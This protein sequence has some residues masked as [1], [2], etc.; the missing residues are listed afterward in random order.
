MVNL[1]WDM[2]VHPATLLDT[3][4]NANATALVTPSITAAAADYGLST[5]PTWS[6]WDGTVEQP[7]D[8]AGVWNGT[9]IV[10]ATTE[11]AP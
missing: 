6:Y 9:T 11:V 8:L 3:V 1:L 5:D 7:L 10:A 2:G 4:A